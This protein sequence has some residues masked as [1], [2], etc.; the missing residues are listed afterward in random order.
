MGRFGEGLRNRAIVARLKEIET[1]TLVL[2]KEL[3]FAGVPVE[4]IDIEHWPKYDKNSVSLKIWN[5]EDLIYK[6]DG[7]GRN[8]TR[9]DVV[10]LAKKR[11]I[12]KRRFNGI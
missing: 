12:L 6:P 2:T 10:A 1:A 7:P 8:L 3:L 5:G 9:D 11:Q 4:S